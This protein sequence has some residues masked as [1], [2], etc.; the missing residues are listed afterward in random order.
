[1]ATPVYQGGTVVGVIGMMSFRTWR[2]ITPRVRHL[3]E[4]VSLRLGHALE[5]VRTVEDA[6]RT[7]DG[8]LL[9]L[10]LALE[11]RDLEV[12][13]HTERVVHLSQALGRQLGVGQEALDD[14]RRGAYLH[15]IGKL[16]V[17]DTI[18]HKPGK[19]DAAEWVLMQSHAVRG[20]EIAS[21][22]PTL[23]R[24][25]LDLI[26]SHHE[27]FDGSGYPDG[28]RAEKIPALA[29]IFAVCDV[30]DALLNA[31]PYKRAWTQREALNE[32]RAQAGKQFDPMVVRGFIELVASLVLPDATAA[33]SA[34]PAQG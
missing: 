24:G 1:M 27:R 30:Y 17:P 12:A 18:L 9:A 25:A 31:R 16:C 22:I 26:R 13:G 15:D 2:P 20:H 34:K 6:R 33:R 8:R 28:L 7:L 10:G 4:A 19:L 29:R 11:A 32:T 5:R 21:R 23:T 14:L 3:L